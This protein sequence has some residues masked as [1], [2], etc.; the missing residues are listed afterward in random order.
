[1]I[2]PIK[3]IYWFHFFPWRLSFWMLFPSVAVWT[4]FAAGLLHSGCRQFPI[5]SLLKWSCFMDLIFSSILVCSFIQEIHDVFG[6]C[7][8]VTC[9]E[10]NTWGITFWKISWFPKKKSV[11]KS[12]SVKLHICRI[13]LLR[14]L[15][16]D[17][18]GVHCPHQL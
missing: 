6:T 2:K 15:R 13:S 5:A 4:G 12:F 10:K 8:P 14:K 3:W 1:M 16:D 11:D 17:L 18:N 7:L 9:W